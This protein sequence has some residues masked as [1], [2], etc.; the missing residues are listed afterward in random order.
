VADEHPGPAYL[1]VQDVADRLQV[2]IST[3][4]AAMHAGRLRYSKFG[5]KC[6]RIAPADLAAYE[7]ACR[8]EPPQINPTLARLRART[9]ASR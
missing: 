9:A 1:T 2:G 8:V 4:Y 7:Q 6:Y 3:V 5:P